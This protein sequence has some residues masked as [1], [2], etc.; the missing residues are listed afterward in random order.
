MGSGSPLSR[1]FQQQRNGEKARRFVSGLCL[2]QLCNSVL[3]SIAAMHSY[4]HGAACL[5]SLVLTISIDK[6]TRAACLT[7]LVL[8]ISIDKGTRS[9]VVIRVSVAPQV[10]HFCCDFVNFKDLTTQSSKMLVG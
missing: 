4:S 9:L 7:S 6:G 8:T 2:S 5:T 1:P 10:L 3:A